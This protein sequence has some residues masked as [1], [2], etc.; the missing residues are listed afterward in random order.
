MIKDSLKSRLIVTVY[1][2]F[3]TSM[4]VSILI[5]YF[6]LYSKEKNA[7]Q[8]NLF[9]AENLVK[10]KIQE[11]QKELEHISSL[12]I[13]DTIILSSL[14]LIDK[15]QNKKEYDS[16]VF[17]D[18]K[19][20]LLDHIMGKFSLVKNYS[21]VVYDSELDPVVIKSKNLDLENGAIL[22]YVGEESFIQKK[23]TKTNINLNNYDKRLHLFKNLVGNILYEKSSIDENIFIAYSIAIHSLNNELI[24]YLKVKKSID[25]DF[26]QSFF[27]LY[28]V[29]VALGFDNV[30]VGDLGLPEKE[31][32]LVNENEHFE[33]LVGSN[34]FFSKSHLKTFLDNKLELLLAYDKTRLDESLIEMLKIFFYGFIITIVIITPFIG[35]FIERNIFKPVGEITKGIENYKQGTFSPIQLATNNEFNFIAN[36]L[37]ELISSLEIKQK[38]LIYSEE[39]MK[40]IINTA[41]IKIFWKDTDFRYIGCNKEFLKDLDL[42]SESELIGSRDKDI[43]WNHYSDIFRSEDESVLNGNVVLNEEQELITQDGEKK[44]IIISKVPLVD[45]DG[46]TIGLLGVY[47][48]ITKDKENKEELKEKEQMLFQQ[49]KMAAMGE[50]IGNIAHQWRQPINAIGIILQKMPVLQRREKLTQEALKINVDKG[51]K[52]ISQMSTTIDDFRDFFKP[53]KNKTTFLLEKAFLKTKDLFGQSYLNNSIELIESCESV[54]VTTLFNELVQIVMN[55][56]NNSKDVLITKEGRRLVFIS[57]EKDSQNGIIKIRDNGGGIP[58]AI[59]EKIFEPYF[60]TKDKDQGTG[61]GLYMSFEMMTKHIGGTITTSNVDYTFE[62]KEYTGAEFTITV[63]L[64]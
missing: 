30:V 12:I 15:Y 6:F 20:A 10:V 13:K 45:A 8:A 17:D 26:V 1:I 22:T 16:V 21:F 56:L 57:I 34:Y 9:K 19:T 35:I 11:T 60:T 50:M 52:I 14:S 55:V 4:L 51:M 63:P 47:K 23:G 31:E 64:G 40:N 62:E 29:K 32:K 54:E 25:K 38:E 44:I 61:I 2:S 58:P 36:K 53:N 43:K 3:I 27:N 46:E 7:A 41:P 49:S 39:L 18:E 33:F 37:N 42:S 5:Q 48:D 24:G 59:I 28:G